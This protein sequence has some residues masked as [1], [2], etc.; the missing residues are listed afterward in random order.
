MVYKMSFDEI[1]DLTAD[2]C[3]TILVLLHAV[4]TRLVPCFL[5]RVTYLLFYSCCCVLCNSSKSI[6]RTR[7]IILVWYIVYVRVLGILY[8]STGTAV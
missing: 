3:M 6:A 7:C 1:L 8:L 4:L 5:R 2:A